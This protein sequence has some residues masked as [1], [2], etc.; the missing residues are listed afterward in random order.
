MVLLK[1]KNYEAALRAAEKTVEL[2]PSLAHIYKSDVE[3]IKKL[4]KKK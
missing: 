2:T 4:M 1:L 3:R